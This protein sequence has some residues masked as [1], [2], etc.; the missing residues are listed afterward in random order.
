MLTTARHDYLQNVYYTVGRMED[1]ELGQLELRLMPLP[2]AV[3]S[4][5]PR[6][7]RLRAAME[8]GHARLRLELRR[9]G[10]AGSTWQPLCEVRLRGPLN[11]DTRELRFSPYQTGQGL[12][13]RGFLHAMRGPSY[14]ASQE[15]RAGE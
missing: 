11:M 15:P 7:A 10:G 3:M 6:G 13:P 14:A 2:L 8:A 5:M 1:A 9:L 4:G 12:V